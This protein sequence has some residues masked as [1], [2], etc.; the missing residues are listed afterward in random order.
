MEEQ[1][2]CPYCGTVYEN[3][4]AVCPLCGTTNAE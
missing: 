4:E 1:K 3:Y 2:K